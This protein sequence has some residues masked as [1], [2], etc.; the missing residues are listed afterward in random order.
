[1]A[2]LKPGIRQNFSASIRSSLSATPRVAESLL[3]SY[4]FTSPALA[5]PTE[6]DEGAFMNFLN[7]VNDIGYYGGTTSFARGWPNSTESKL[8][9][10]SK[11]F[12]FFF[13]EPNPW[14]GPY[15]GLATHV[16]DVVFLFQNY[17]DKLPP[18]QRAAAEGF[19]LDL[20]RFVAGQTPWEAN[21]P[22]HRSAKVFGPST[23]DGTTPTTKLIADSE[24]P[25]S[26]RRMAILE[27]GKEV[28]FDKLAE[29]FGRFRTGL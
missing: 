15:Q 19:G 21:Q 16:L 6:D 29:A 20:M 12:T 27:L 10:D 23:R 14:P 24:S 3:E 17:N 11:I 13:N 25:E 8:K 26:G 2:H 9:S 22:G 5:D 1:M 4:G 7:F 28:G 18:K